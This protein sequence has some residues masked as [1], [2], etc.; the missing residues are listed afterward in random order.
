MPRRL[1]L[2]RPLHRRLSLAA[3]L[4]SGIAAIG[5][6][7]PAAGPVPPPLTVADVDTAKARFPNTSK[8]SLDT[9]RDLFAARCNGCHNY[10]D[11]WKVDDAR[12]PEIMKRMG[13]KAGLDEAQSHAV[14]SFIRVARSR[15]APP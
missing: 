15:P 7:F 14:L 12:W 5:C 2:R 6:G 11:V 13:N 1:A 9:G 3:A 4:V 10:P 8:D